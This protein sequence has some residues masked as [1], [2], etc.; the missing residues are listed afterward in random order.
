M[1]LGGGPTVVPGIQALDGV[2]LAMRR[3]VPRA[4]AFDAETFDGFHLY[5]LDFSFRAHRAGYKLGVA[6]ELTLIHASTGHFNRTW[7]V[8][9][10]RFPA[11]HAD[12][13]TL[14]LP[15]VFHYGAALLPDRAALE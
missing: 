14:A 9:G 4:V 1:L 2:F 8:Y 5:D 3:D 7:Q 10:Q 11:K 6:P 15:G 13:L 12:A